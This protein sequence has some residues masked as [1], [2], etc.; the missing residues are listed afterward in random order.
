MLFFLLPKSFHLTLA[1]NVS[2]RSGSKLDEKGGI[3][4][5]CPLQTELMI[6][7]EIPFSCWSVM[8]YI[9]SFNLCFEVSYKLAKAVII[10]FW[11]SSTQCQQIQR[12]PGS[13]THSYST[14]ECVHTQL[15]KYALFCVYR[16][17]IYFVLP[18]FV[19]LNV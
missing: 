16:E 8:N 6:S 15:I 18:A 14:C 11:S 1:A 4:K 12:H 10:A 17:Y 2:G 3:K 5:Y 7:G 13:C 9:P 19:E